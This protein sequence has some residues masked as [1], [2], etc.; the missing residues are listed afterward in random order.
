MSNIVV[1]HCLDGRVIKGTSLDVTPTKPDCHIRTADQQTVKVALADLKAL[2]FVKSLEG[3]PKHEY[4][5]EP[6]AGDP[7]LTGSH[8]VSLTFKD[9]ERLMA[10]ANRFPPV[11]NFFFV[12]PVDGDGNT[13]RVLVNRA[14]VVEMGS[15][16]Q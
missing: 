15:G 12:L 14:A 3:N 11:G 16:E 7:R 1:A 13:V 6:T 5:S 8:R 9:G 10:L 2:Y 4:A